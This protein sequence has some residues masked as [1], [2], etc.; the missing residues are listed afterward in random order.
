MSLPRGLLAIAFTLLWVAATLGSFLA[1]MAVFHPDNPQE[2]ALAAI[3]ALSV[4]MVAVLTA[5]RLWRST[6]FTPPGEWRQLHLL[7]VPLVVVV[8]PLFAG[9]KPLDTG[10]LWLLVAGY[11]LT[12]FAEEAMFRGIIPLTLDRLPVLRM[13]TISALLFGIVHLSNIIIRGNPAIIASQAVGAA[14][15]GFAYVALRLRNRT[16]V[17]LIVLHFLHDL[18]LQ[19]S[20]LP[21]IPVAVTQDVVLLAFGLWLLWPRRDAMPA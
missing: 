12:G 17:P 20:N 11:A 9:I 18:I 14:C 10:A 16:L 6:G 19:L 2:G 7:I 21:L 5:L 8:A 3:A 13:A 1:Y 15:F 4:L